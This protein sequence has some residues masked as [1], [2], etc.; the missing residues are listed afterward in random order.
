MT[1]IGENETPGVPQERTF[2]YEDL[3]ETDQSIVEQ[4]LQQ[5]GNYTTS[6]EAS[7]LIFRTDAGQANVVEYQN[8]SYLLVAETPLS[9]ERAGLGLYLVWIPLTLVGA[10]LL[11]SGFLLSPLRHKLRERWLLGK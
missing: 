5:G 10:V 4:T 3:P 6:Q 7:E 11:F 9:A 1:E 2:Q 8:E